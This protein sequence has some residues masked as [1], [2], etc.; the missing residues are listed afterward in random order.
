PIIA[1]SS[2]NR[3]NR[4]PTSV[5]RWSICKREIAKKR[6]EKPATPSTFHPAK[7]STKS[8]WKKSNRSSGD[9]L[10]EL[11]GGKIS[12]GLH[13]LRGFGNRNNLSVL[14]NPR[15]PCNPRLILFSLGK[16]VITGKLAHTATESWVVS[17]REL[18]RHV[19]ASTDRAGILWRAK[20]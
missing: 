17:R 9:D 6:S 3:L 5:S 19:S 15:N 20:R 12:R 4:M 1:R 18:K 2:S 10:T 13:G 14:L 11:P 7:T 8:S 16:A